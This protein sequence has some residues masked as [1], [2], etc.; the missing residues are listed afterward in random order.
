MDERVKRYGVV[1]PEVLTSYDGLGFLSAMI[2]GHIPN[3]PL[4]ETL[5]F[6]LTEVDHGRAVF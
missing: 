1:S 3:P 6:H 5:G 2:A 4:S